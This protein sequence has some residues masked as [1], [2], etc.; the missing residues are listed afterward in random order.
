MCNV[1]LFSVTYFSALLNKDTT[2][3]S[4]PSLTYRKHN[5]MHLEAAIS[6]APVLPLPFYPMGK[7][8]D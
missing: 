6:I 5:L 7:E 2:L 1:H 8:A 3:E 4:L